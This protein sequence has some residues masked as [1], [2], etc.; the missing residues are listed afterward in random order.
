MLKCD[1]HNVCVDEFKANILTRI[2]NSGVAALI[3]CY[4][5]TGHSLHNVL[6]KLYARNRKASE[7]SKFKGRNMINRKPFEAQGPEVFAK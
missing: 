4:F 2:I 3:Y 5:S 1:T 6:C 7:A